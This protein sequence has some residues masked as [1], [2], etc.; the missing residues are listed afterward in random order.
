LAVPVAVEIDGNQAV[1]DR[2]GLARQ[3]LITQPGGD[4]SSPVY[5]CQKV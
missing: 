2:P 5:R 4:S 1:Q 3:Q